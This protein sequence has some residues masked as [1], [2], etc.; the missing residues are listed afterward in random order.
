MIG[1]CERRRSLVTEPNGLRSGVDDYW[2][3]LDR[4][5]DELFDV[6]VVDADA[7]V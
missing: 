5:S 6:G 1:G 3:S 4:D 7:A 2:R